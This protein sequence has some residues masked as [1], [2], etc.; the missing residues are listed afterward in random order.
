MRRV[1]GVTSINFIKLTGPSFRHSIE[2]MLRNFPDSCKIDIISVN[3]LLLLLSCRSSL[4]RVEHAK[5]SAT[6]AAFKQCI[7]KREDLNCHSFIL[8]PC[9]YF[10][11]ID[12]SRY[13]SES[14]LFRCIKYASPVACL[15]QTTK[16]V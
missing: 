11:I 14:F 7:K 8:I 6:Y 2:K 1:G 9:H 15:T 5:D 12:C 3:Y 16:Q 10:C 4:M 13:D